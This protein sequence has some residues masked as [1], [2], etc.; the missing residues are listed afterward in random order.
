[1]SEVVGDG[2]EVYQ[3]S[4]TELWKIES[5]LQGMRG[6]VDCIQQL[7]KAVESQVSRLKLG[8]GLSLWPNPILHSLDPE[9]PVSGGSIALKPYNYCDRWFKHKDFICAPC[10]HLYHP[11][12]IANLVLKERKCFACGVVFH[13]L[14]FREA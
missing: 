8:R 2:E 5:D 1:M 3:D 12:C 4:E 9:H 10:G 7:T 14:W 11:F 6:D 13:P